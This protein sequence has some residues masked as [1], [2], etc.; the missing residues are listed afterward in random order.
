MKLG[1]NLKIDVTKIDKKR[2]FDGKNGKYI[3][4]VTFVDTENKDKFGN[5]GMIRHGKKSD[6]TKEV[7]KDLPILGNSKIFWGDIEKEDIPF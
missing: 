2:L 5:R 6:E 7:L 1:I 3:D 4:L